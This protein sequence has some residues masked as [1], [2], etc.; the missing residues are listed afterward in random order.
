MENA[1]KII[2]SGLDNAGKT[3]ILT[4]LD[5]KFDFEKE[6]M[7]LKPTVKVEYSASNFLGNRVYYW[8]MGGQKQYRELYEKNKDM[9]FAG[10]DL[11]VYIIDIQD[12]SRFDLSLE[13]LNTILKYFQN[14]EMEN[15]PLIISFHKFDPQLR[16]SEE[17]LYN[18]N[19]LREKILKE[20]PK[21]KI[22]FQQTS[23][24][25]IISIVQL[26]SYGLSVFDKAFFELSILLEDYLE[27]FECSSLILFDQNGIIISEFYSELIDSDHYIILLENI[28]EHLFLLKRML[29]EEK[30]EH[31]FFTIE[32]NFLSYLHRIIYKKYNYYI[33]VIIEEN[34][35]ETLLEKFPNLVDEIFN[36]FDSLFA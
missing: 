26:V 22:L 15:V 13:Y 8:D 7:Q 21:F 3:S 16:D 23:I 14:N 29:E 32:D 4:A 18:I 11:L 36:I 10:T 30:T 33:S 2:I 12:K 28:K 6:I 24:Y 17:I 34:K 35:K 20:N 27:E 31:N 5:K 9:Y 1:I 19:D 25:D